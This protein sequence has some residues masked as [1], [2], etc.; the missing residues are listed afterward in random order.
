MNPTAHVAGVG[1]GMILGYLMYRTALVPRR[2]AVLGLV[3]GP[4]LA[5]AF[6]LALFGRSR[7]GPRGSACS[8]RQ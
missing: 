8:R 5:V 3:G 6:V 7:S 4:M 2:M 1:N